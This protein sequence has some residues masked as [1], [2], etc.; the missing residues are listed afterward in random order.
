FGNQCGCS[1]P[2]GPM[3]VV[4][5]AVVT[6]MIA[7]N[8]ENGMAM[9]FTV[10]MMAG[11]FQIL[12]G[13]LRLG[14]YVTLMPYTVISGFMSGI[15]F[16]LIVLQIPP[17]LGHESPG[18]GVVGAITSFPELFPTANPVEVVLGVLTVAVIFFT[19]NQVKKWVPP[20]LAALVIG[21]VVSLIFFANA[22]IRIIG[23]IPMGLPEL[24]VPAFSPEQLQQMILDAVVLGMLGC[25]DSLLTSVIADSLTQTQHD[26][27]K[28]II[29][30]GIGNIMSGLA[31][32][33]PGAGATMGTVVNIQTGAR[34]AVS[35]LTRSLILLV[36]ILWAG[37][38]TQN[39][40]LAVLAGIALKVGI[41]I[42]DWKFL[43]RAHK[44]SLKA[45]AIMYGVLLL[46]V[47]VDLIVAVGVGVFV[48]NILTIKRLADIQAEQVKAIDAPT[49]EVLEN[50]E[51]KQ[52]L[53]QA[54]G[55]ALLLHLGGPMSFGAAKAVTQRQSILN[56]YKTLIIDLS[57]VPMLGV[58]ATLGLE[59][60]VDAAY[61]NSVEVFIVGDDGKIK[62]RLQKFNILDRVPYQ[63][64][65]ATRVEAL[66][67][68]VAKIKG[69][70]DESSEEQV[71]AVATA[72][73]STPSDNSQE[74]AGVSTISNG[75]SSSEN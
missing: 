36:V 57:D 14:K 50:D 73:T 20:Q 74:S 59:K 2:T 45:A 65:V 31:G 52:L 71:E 39:I 60:V 13:V 42:V 62:Q 6:T 49:G 34:T 29:G 53:K 58:T 38:L 30:Q 18:G 46:T 24:Q 47:F 64:R 21:T 15:G 54:G 1:E 68:A 33:L 8:P 63:N 55:K 17:F 75:T 9:A 27:D 70:T 28:E 41:D 37:G 35:G 43:K 48:A 25:I 3:T 61:N 23:E 10:V 19:P 11:V 44:L 5:T 7:A 67:L 51:A 22:D 16:I 69:Y 40:P 66:R 32:G 4:M 26:S 72:T 12:F 56:N